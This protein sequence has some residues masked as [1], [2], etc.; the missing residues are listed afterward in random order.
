VWDGAISG[1]P[2]QI[3]PNSTGKIDDPMTFGYG[4][5]A[6]GSSVQKSTLRNKYLLLTP[7]GQPTA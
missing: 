5:D 6:T 1:V 2:L 3:S 7:K 4:I